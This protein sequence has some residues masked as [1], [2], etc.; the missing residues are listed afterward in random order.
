M[1][2]RR[3]RCRQP[4]VALVVGI[5]SALGAPLEA[6][7]GRDWY[8]KLAGG[9]Y[10]L[11]SQDSGLG[12]YV[13]LGHQATRMSVELGVTAAPGYSTGFGSADVAGMLRLCTG[14][15]V[16]PSLGAGAGVMFDADREGVVTWV[17]LGATL[18]WHLSEKNAVSVS[19]RLARH[20]GDRGPHVISIGWKHTFG[21]RP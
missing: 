3:R 6:G 11:R 1:A 14:C 4:Q 9:Y 21:T 10:A 2:R 17:G 7:D 20:G 12:G 5:V 18:D 13:A 8:A 16:R 19:G 15:A